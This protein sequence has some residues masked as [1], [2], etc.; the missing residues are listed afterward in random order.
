LKLEET[1]KGVRISVHVYSNN[2]EQVIEEAFT[3]YL[4]AKITAIDNKIPLAP[5]GIKAR[6][7][8][9]RPHHKDKEIDRE[10]QQHGSENVHII[11]DTDP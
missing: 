1:A 3:T 6:K 11:Q 2:E 5:V 9:N 7:K 4:K 10:I 8:R